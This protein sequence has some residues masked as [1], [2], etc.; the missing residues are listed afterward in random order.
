MELQF[1]DVEVS[2]FT[3]VKIKVTHY[4]PF[5]PAKLNALPEDC[6]PEEHAEVEFE[7]YDIEDGS[8]IVVLNEEALANRILEVLENE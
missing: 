3:T 1:D 7:V 2:M 6:Y 4:S 8:E 5:V